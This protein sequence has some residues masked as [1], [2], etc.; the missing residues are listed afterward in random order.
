MSFFF[1]EWAGIRASRGHFKGNLVPGKPT[2][3][4][5]CY[6]LPGLGFSLG[7]Q[8]ES[9]YLPPPSWRHLATMVAGDRGTARGI[10]WRAFKRLP[11]SESIFVQLLGWRGPSL[12][13]APHI[14]AIAPLSQ[15]R[16]PIDLGT[17]PTLAVVCP[18]L[19][20]PPPLCPGRKLEAPAD[21]RCM[22][23]A[24]QVW[25]LGFATSVSPR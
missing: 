19:L 23:D 6:T 21:K 8:R 9:Q 11:C 15:E 2:S 10:L 13:L 20:P 14:P 7:A 1:H 5:R 22:E 25:A 18:G 17:R 16:A 4:S 3:Y 12:P 24:G